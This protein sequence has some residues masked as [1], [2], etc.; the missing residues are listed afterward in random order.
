MSSCVKSRSA[1]C[2]ILSTVLMLASCSNGTSTNEGLAQI[3]VPKGLIFTA[4][5]SPVGV[6]VTMVPAVR[7]EI[8]DEAGAT[9]PGAMDEV[10]LTLTNAQ[11]GAVLGGT[12]SRQAVLGVAVF[13]DLSVDAR[14]T[15]YILVASATGFDPVASDP[16]DVVIPAIPVASDPFDV[17]IPA[18]KDNSLY[19]DAAGALSN[20]QG[21]N[22]VA[23]R[24][25]QATGSIRRGL[26]AFDLA[27]KI[28]AGVKITGAQL[29]LKLGGGSSD[30]AMV[31]VHKALADWGEG[32]S[33][34]GEKQGQGADSTLSDA[35]WIHTFYDT[36]FWATPGGDFVPTASAEVQVVGNGA[37][38]WTSEAMLADVQ[39]WIDNPMQNFGWLLLGDE[40]VSGSAKKFLSRENSR[41][42][43]VLALTYALAADIPASQDNTLIESATGA[44]S[45]GAG[46]NFYVGRTGQASDYRRRAVLRFDLNSIPAGATIVTATLQMNVTTVSSTSS[47]A[48]EL[49][50]TTAAWGE[51]TSVCTGAKGVASTTGDATWIHTFYDT[52]LWGTAGGEF[53]APVS[54]STSVGD[55][56]VY[57]WSGTGLVQDVQAWLDNPSQNF[58]WTIVGDESG[59]SGAKVFAS[60]ENAT[61]ALQPKLEVTY[62]AP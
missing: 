42:F 5:P 38:V 41:D 31:A 9:V 55:M 48:V 22:L 27:G 53:G 16:F 33:D 20:G 11:S 54:A 24:T 50:A 2:T 12:T 37:Y 30:P 49:H 10:V 15:G 19:E 28:P 13:D 14:G 58:G 43:P 1:L 35:T 56:G 39:S 61:T 29:R 45:C 52:S 21:V 4:Q 6:S 40:A 51:G 23:G 26:I 32:A 18:I 17:V 3:Q 59:A 34:A 46:E 44:V 60:R 36:A 62:T 57:D 25:G 7:V 47:M 8:V